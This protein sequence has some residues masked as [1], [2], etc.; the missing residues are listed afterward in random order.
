MAKLLP[1]R[2]GKELMER[3]DEEDIVCAGVFESQYVV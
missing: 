1:S 3:D 2:V